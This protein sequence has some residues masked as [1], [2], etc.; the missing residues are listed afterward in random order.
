MREKII[1]DDSGKA[2]NVLVQCLP[3]TS[4]QKKLTALL[5]VYDVADDDDG[6]KQGN[7]EVFYKL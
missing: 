5:H 7:I 6:K 4:K 1:W 2:L 3:K